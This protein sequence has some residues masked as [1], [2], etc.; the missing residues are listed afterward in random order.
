MPLY[1]VQSSIEGHLKL[2]IRTDNGKS[3]EEKKIKKKF[4]IINNRKKEKT[5]KC[6]AFKKKNNKICKVHNN[7]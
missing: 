4:L 5:M 7:Q 6:K 2:R 1:S 3:E